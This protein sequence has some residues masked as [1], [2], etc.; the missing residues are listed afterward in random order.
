MLEKPV[1]TNKF[2]FTYKFAIMD[3]NGNHQEYEKGVDRIADM[4]ILTGQDEPANAGQY[5]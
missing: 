5:Q 4:E 2:F 3:S 1:I